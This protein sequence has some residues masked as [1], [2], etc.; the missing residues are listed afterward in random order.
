MYL[1]YIYF[2]NGAYG[3]EAAAKVYFGATTQTL[4]VSQAALLAGVIKSATN[5]APHLHLDRSVKR[6]DL[7]LSLMAEQGFITEAQEAQAKAEQIVLVP[8]VD[9]KYDY[10]TDMVLYEA[11][12]I[13]NMDTEDLLA[14]GYRIYTTLDPDL[15]NEVEAL[16]ENSA[17]FPENAADGEQCQ[18]ALVI[19][20]SETSEIRAVMGGRQYET[21]R[22]LNRV[23]DMKRQPGSTIKPVLVYAPAMEK[24]NYS[25]ATLVLDEKGDFDGYVPK[26]F[27][28]SYAGWVTVRKALASSLNLPAVRTLQAV[29]VETAKLYASRV[30][31]PFE[32]E[33]TGLPLA[34]GGFTKGVTPL[35]LC[36]AFTPF[37]NGGYYSYPSCIAR[38]TDARG[39]V[40]YER[41]Q[42]KTGVLS[43]DTAFLMTSMLQSAVQEG[44]ARRVQIDGV[45]LAG[46]TGTMGADNISGNRDAWTIAYNTD[47]TICCWMGFDSTDEVHCLPSSVTGGTYPAMLVRQVFEYLYSDQAAPAFVQPN[48]VVQARI[49]LKTLLVE[50]EPQLASAFTPEDQTL[51][52][53]FLEGDAPTEYSTYWTVPKPPGDL[54]V[55]SG[56]GGYPRISFTPLEN[57]VIYR[58]MRSDIATGQTVKIGEF[59]GSRDKVTLRDDTALYGH[60]YQYYVLPVHPEIQVDGTPLTGAP[61]LIKEI[62]LLNEEDYMP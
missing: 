1:N 51:E 11:E 20:D 27:S 38:I 44:T 40:V 9:M 48:G 22:G 36:N 59:T 29:G 8:D 13:L 34:L 4:T 33:D 6:R 55:S 25:P 61:S 54:T 14:S 37:A 47:Y 17:N 5:Y 39:E 3:I 52:E 26:N 57:Y 12:D 53:Y 41:P 46:K 7:V 49:D 23:V 24:L 32:A 30:G 18:S 2:G 10:F 62:A 31:I 42:T 16:F 45:S 58:L 19:L 15:Q 35:S 28:D 50:D 21:R 56:A 43:E 60:T